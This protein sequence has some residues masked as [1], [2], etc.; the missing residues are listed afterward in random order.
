MSKQR[1][2]YPLRLPLDLYEEIKRWADQEMRSVN[3][4]IEYLLR[5][6]VRKRRNGGR[7]GHADHD[8]SPD[9]TGK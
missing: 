6:A 7:S 1:K 3:G 8:D 9:E 5:D 2:N 4:Q